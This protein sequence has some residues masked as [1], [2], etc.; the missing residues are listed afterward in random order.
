MRKFFVM[1]ALE[2]FYD[3][4]VAATAFTPRCDKID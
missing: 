4:F 2:G 1:L 3:A